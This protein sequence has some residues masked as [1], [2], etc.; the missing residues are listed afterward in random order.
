MLLDIYCDLSREHVGWV[1]TLVK[2]ATQGGLLAFYLA[3]EK[4]FALIDN[5][6][7][8][9]EVHHLVVE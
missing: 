3:F 8:F 2:R 5:S 9:V 6:N 1:I 4:C 7:R